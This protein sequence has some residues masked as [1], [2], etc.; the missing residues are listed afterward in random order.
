ML[1]YLYGLPGV[2]K[3]FVGN[4]FEKEFNFKFIDADNYL[5]ENM[6]E[7]L[8]E[9]KHFTPEEVIEYH[10]IIAFNIFEIKSNY[11]N[12]VIAQA[13]LFKKNRNLIKVLNP[14]IKFIHVKS[15]Y[16]TIN[17]RI[18]FRKGYVD[19][20]YSDYLQKFLEISEFDFEIVNFNN[21]NQ[22]YLIKQ[23]KKI[24]HFSI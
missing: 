4:I 17:Q 9:R 3:N 7:K 5:T 24:I 13:S 20:E 16:Q 10:K 11:S 12:L 18:K 8:R 19:K 14:E 15:N 1:F 6:K 21:D 23:I 22:N 2:G